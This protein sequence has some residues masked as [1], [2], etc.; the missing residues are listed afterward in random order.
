M[1]SHFKIYISERNRFEWTIKDD[2]GK[3][4]HEKFVAYI[5]SLLKVFEVRK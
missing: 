2:L 5:D 1:N 4:V 3:G